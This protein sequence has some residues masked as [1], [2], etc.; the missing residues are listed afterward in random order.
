MKKQQASQLRVLCPLSDS[1]L[2][3][4]TTNTYTLITPTLV[5]EPTVT[6]TLLILAVL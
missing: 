3:I 5:V 4:I 2:T 1:V 6:V